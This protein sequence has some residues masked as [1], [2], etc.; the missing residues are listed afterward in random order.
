MRKYPGEVLLDFGCGAGPYS[1]YLSR[2]PNVKVKSIDINESRIAESKLIMQNIGRNNIEFHVGNGHDSLR[3]FHNEN[4]DCALAIEV[5]Q[6]VAD[7]EGTLGEMY[8]LLKPGGYLIGHIPV[9]GYLRETEYTLFDDNNIRQFLDKSGFE[10]IELKATFGGA[11]RQLCNFYKK[12][13]NFKY[14]TA[15]LYPFLLAISYAFKVEA[16]DGDYRFF[17]ARRPL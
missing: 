6:Y 4:F 14:I 11:I 17:I 9:L 3:L 16:P 12:I 2:L 5:F 13:V 10:V 1:F 15:L 8:Q 7:L